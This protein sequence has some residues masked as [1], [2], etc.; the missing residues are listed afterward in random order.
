MNEADRNTMLAI[1]VYMS[2]FTLY[3][4][5]GRIQHVFHTELRTGRPCVTR[6]V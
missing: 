3:F 6:L 2:D 1:A 4:F 5:D